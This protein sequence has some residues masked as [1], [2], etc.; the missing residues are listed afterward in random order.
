[1]LCS[2]CVCVQLDPQIHLWCDTCDTCRPARQRSRSQTLMYYKCLI[3]ITGKATKKL[4]Y[5]QF[6]PRHLSW[7]R[8]NY[9]LINSIYV[10]KLN[11]LNH[12]HFGLSHFSYST[13]ISLAFNTS[14]SLQ[15]MMKQNIHVKFA[16][17]HKQR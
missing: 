1:M 17:C 5:C 4:L 14:I 15:Q 16:I 6:R 13:Y 12:C 8:Q 3:V 9:G 2:L 7:P 11:F 10:F